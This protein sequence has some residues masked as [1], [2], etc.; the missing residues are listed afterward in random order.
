MTIVVKL[1]GARAIDPAGLL[2]DVAHLTANGQR[3]V[4]V[5]GGS[6]AIDDT[7]ETLGREP[8]YV[9]TP[10][11]V[12]GRFTDEKTMQAVTMTLARV[13]TDLVTSLI[14]AGIKAVGLN[15]VDGELLHGPRTG[16][17]RVIEDGRK[18][19]KR[20]DH[21][22]T[23]TSVNGKLLEILL[24]NGYVPVVTLP[25][26][27]ED[28]GQ[29]LPV[30]A[31][32]DGAAGAIA[33]ELGATLVVL[34]D[35][36]GIFRDVDDHDSRIETVD[37]PSSLDEAREVSQGFMERKLMAAID[38]LEGGATDVFIGDANARS[39]VT[40]ALE[41]DATAILPAALYETP[42]GEEVSVP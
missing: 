39:P 23:V 22:G 31:D 18:M 41:G 21:A 9:E 34:S 15:G 19:L 2:V 5:H 30:N 29:S 40:G 10:E 14:D 27:G 17:V 24:D 36:A 26:L 13:N 1:G 38:A 42:E 11:G 33:G 7:I 28:R 8:T 37:S 20:G 32:A 12:I 25:M 3:V 6:T 35:V 16:T 4:I